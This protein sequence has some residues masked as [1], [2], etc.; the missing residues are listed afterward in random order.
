MNKLNKSILNDA[1]KVA[2]ILPMQAMKVPAL[3]TPPPP[4][5]PALTTPPP[6]DQMIL[7]SMALDLWSLLLVFVY[8]FHITLLRLKIKNKLMIA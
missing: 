3:P 8:F 2:E 4:L 6:Q 7:T 5:P 1:K